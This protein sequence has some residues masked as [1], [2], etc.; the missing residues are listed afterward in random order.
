MGVVRLHAKRDR[1]DAAPP[2]IASLLVP[3]RSVLAG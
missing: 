2:A 3:K 1:F